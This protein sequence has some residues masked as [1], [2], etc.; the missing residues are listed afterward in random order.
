MH[1]VTLTAK[2]ITSPI[3]DI[4]SSAPITATIPVQLSSQD[5]ASVVAFAV[6][7]KNIHIID[8]RC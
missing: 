7:K 4:V 5:S 3:I 1:C 8:S 6:I 2:E